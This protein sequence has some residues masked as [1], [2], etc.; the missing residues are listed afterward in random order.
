MIAFLE[1]A[2]PPIPYSTPA[3]E[4]YPSSRTSFIITKATPPVIAQPE[5][6]E[7]VA[8]IVSFCAK[9]GIAFTIRGGGHDLGARSVVDGVAVI[10]LR[11][12]HW[13]RVA[14]D[15]KTAVIG[16]GVLASKVL[17]VL[18]QDGLAT[19]MAT[20]ASVGYV[21]W[22]ILGGYGCYSPSLGLGVDQIVAATV[23]SPQGEIRQADEQLL[24]C[25]KGGGGGF[26]IVVEMTIKVYPLPR[27]CDGSVL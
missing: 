16:G 15:K 13:V 26:G 1:G 25:L 3:S 5:T 24:K 4:S 21:G 12:L 6:A 19:A 14:E 11:S 20:I 9:N 22:S 27:V 17:E 18:G 10:D 7:A 23:V 8:A 2:K